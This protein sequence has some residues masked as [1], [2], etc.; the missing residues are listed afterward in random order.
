MS[1][2]LHFI[3]F[4]ETYQIIEALLRLLANFLYVYA[5]AGLLLFVVIGW[6]VAL[7]FRSLGKEL[8]NSPLLNTISHWTTVEEDEL[9]KLMI[10]WKSLHVLL[11]DTV[12][13]INDCFGPILLIWVTHIF[14]GFISTPFYI[15]GGFH[16]LTATN[17]VILAINIFL[18]VTL[19]FHLF[20]ITGVSSRI[21]NE[22]DAIERTT[23]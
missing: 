20:V 1:F 22:V 9:T 7:G 14:F 6:T 5:F 19:T 12:D 16:S 3:E 23:L 18:M 17:S 2:P 11:C 21:W 4:N 10:K 13:G 8:L 15:V